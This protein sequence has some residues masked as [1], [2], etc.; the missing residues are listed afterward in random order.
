MYIKSS[1]L[2]LTLGFIFGINPLVLAFP[3]QAALI[4]FNSWNQAGDVT[5]PSLGQVDLSTN[6]LQ[7]DDSPSPDSD[8]NFSNISAIDSLILESILGLSYQNLDPEPNNLVFAFEGSGLENQYTFTEEIILSF[9]WTFLTNDQTLNIS[10]FD[11]DDYAFIA[12]ND[13]VQTLASTNSSVSTLIPS[14]TNFNREVSGSYTQKFSPGNYSIALGI[15]DVG[16]FELTSAL[17]VNNAQISSQANQK[18]PEPN[19]LFGLL[20]STGFLI[21]SFFHWR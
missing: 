12:L 4:N 11:F 6:S 14:D 5:T 3:S 7:S 10:G 9:N 19:S 8:F 2:T 17:R 16:S 21:V 18:V 15:V 13:Q 1:F 20:V